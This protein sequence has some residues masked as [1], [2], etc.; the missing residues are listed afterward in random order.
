[1]VYGLG[2]TAVLVVLW[3]VLS[4]SY[5]LSGDHSILL[6]M[7][8][9]S[10]AAT[11]GLAVRM[12]ILDRETVPLAPLLPLLTYWSW[13]G[14][15]IVAANIAVIRLIMKPDVDIEPRLVRVPVDLRSGLARCVFANSITLTPGTVTVDIEND[16]F[17]VH[18]LDNSFT[19]PEGFAEM[20]LRTD[21]ASDGKREEA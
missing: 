12:R 13:L 7:T 5:T 18:A 20:A 14:R 1:M 2:L 10:L 3:L 15:E 9:V 6:V 16:G 21:V 11:V 17:L 4:G 19:A 8:V